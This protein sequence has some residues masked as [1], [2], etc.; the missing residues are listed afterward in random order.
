MK[1][2][3]GL[4]VI[5]LLAAALG[6]PAFAQ[7]AV[8]ADGAVKA[9]DSPSSAA[10]A[11]QLYEEASTYAR[12][13]FE[14][15]EKNRLPFDR[16]LEAKTYQEQRDMALRHA[17]LLTERGPLRGT[18]LY[19]AG[20]LYALAGRAE[21]A[22]ETLRRF[23]SEE[24][25]A[26][27]DL[28]QQAR[29]NVV[30]RAAQLD[31]A[32]EAEKFLA[33]Y[34]ASSP[35]TDADLHRMH[36]VLASLY[37]KKKDHARAA[38]HARGAYA[39]ALGILKDERIEQRDRD[40]A[41]FAAGAFLANSLIRAGDRAAAVRL[42]QEMRGRA[43][44]IPSARLYRQATGML[45]ENGER[46][47]EPPAV[48]GLAAAAAPE[49]KVGEWIDQQPVNLA[50]LRGK[51]V[52]LDFW[53]TWCGPCRYTIPKLN[54]LHAKYKDRGLV[55][56]GLTEYYGSGEGRSLSPPEELESLRRFKKRNQIEY[57][58]GVSGHE[59]NGEAYGV[60]SLPT[61]VLI[62]RRGR[63]RFI[64]VSAS[65]EEARIMASMIEKLL[66]EQ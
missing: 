22:L 58:F 51:V 41:V 66:A 43:V 24:A 52:L 25:G 50:G 53:A 46:L 20:L 33:E 1:I 14:E 23:L 30:Q 34:A 9:G 54:A 2:S 55:I 3:N 64:T 61:A 45:L 60:T 13:K 7:T 17:T 65:D 37:T 38:S 28:R 59:E 27:A 18:D 63:V 5:I 10:T 36:T 21:P 32:D 11:K 44:A 8:A 4:A 48:E 56:L 57:G 15:F 40:A 39:A 35:R 26:P 19:Y 47:S 12:R 16:A 6:A 62:D 31:R 49:I 42:I 29:V